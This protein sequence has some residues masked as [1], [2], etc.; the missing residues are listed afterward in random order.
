MRDSAHP[1]FMTMG[2]RS[3]CPGELTTMWRESRN[4]IESAR[5]LSFGTLPLNPGERAVH[6]ITIQNESPYREARP[7]YLRIVDGHSESFAIAGARSA[8]H[9][10]G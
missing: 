4:I 2:G 7:L 10:Q 5:P 8:E 1:L 9:H 3:M 6:E